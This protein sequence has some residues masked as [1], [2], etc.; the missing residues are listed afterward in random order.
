[1]QRNPEQ[2]TQ[3]ITNT[4]TGFTVASGAMAYLNDNAAAIGALCAIASLMVA[5]GFGIANLII[6]KREAGKNRDALIDEIVGQIRS[7][8]PSLDFDH[9]KIKERRTKAR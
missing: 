1:M 5:I 8:N 2:V 6:R 3:M 7:E 9:S 4:A